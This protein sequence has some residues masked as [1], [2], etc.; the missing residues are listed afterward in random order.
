MSGKINLSSAQ[1][2]LVGILTGLVLVGAVVL[3]TEKCV[4]FSTFRC[5]TEVVLPGISPGEEE[6]IDDEKQTVTEPR[7][8]E[9]VRTPEPGEESPDE[10]TAVPIDTS[11]IGGVAYRTFEI[12]GENNRFSPSRLIVNEG[13]SLVLN[14]LAVDG[15]YNLFIP[16]LGVF[17]SASEGESKRHIFQA[18]TAGDYEFYCRDI[19]SEE[20]RG[21]LIVNP[22]E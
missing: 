16:D 1:A 21:V 14:F 12:R 17:I 4:I 15:D 10:E 5:K 19:C 2:A 11:P 3:L 18:S 6:L 7:E 8:R 20:T 13:D 22:K 9:P